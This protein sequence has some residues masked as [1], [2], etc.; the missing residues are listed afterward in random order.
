LVLHRILVMAGLQERNLQTILSPI[1]KIEDVKVD[2]IRSYPGVPRERLSYL[3]PPRTLRKSVV[4][5]L[6]WKILVTVRLGL[7]A[8]FTC[9]LAVFSYPHLYLAFL[10]SILAR[11]PLLQRVIASS[12]EFIWHGPII[13]RM[14]VRMSK[15]A[16]II[17]VSDQKT[18]HYLARWGIPDTAIVRFRR[19]DSVDLTHFFPM[20]LEKSV[21]L[22]VVTRLSPEKH[23]EI[24]VDIVNCLRNSFPN[25]KASI[26][27]DG[28]MRKN[29]EDY[30][31]SL[32]LSENIKF[33]GWVS[34]TVVLNQLLNSAKIFVLNSSHEGGPL[35]VIEAMAAGLCCVS[36]NVGEIPQIISNES[37]GF[38]VEKHDDIET[39]VNIIRNLLNDPRHLRK[40][41]ERASHV[42][43]ER[44]PHS[45]TQLWKKIINGF[46]SLA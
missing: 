18:V 4:L 43:K 31:H 23:V 1:L 22:I 37:N 40:L 46:S 14:T 20:G 45:Q 29:L 26:V 34:S 9:V 32:D 7:A 6:I 19:L 24:F 28:E 17:F 15:R 42:G 11:R 16:S 12:H 33:H 5:S 2:V 38:I 3:C 41:Q 13:E 10:A 35:T 36:S 44:N 39:Y 27:G 8:R 30:V 25:I 21:E